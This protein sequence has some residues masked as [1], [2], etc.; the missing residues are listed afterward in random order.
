MITTRYD[1]LK[2]HMSSIDMKI[3]M[4]LRSSYNKSVVA[5]AASITSE[6]GRVHH[7]E[8]QHAA[9]TMALAITNACECYSY[10]LVARSMT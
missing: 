3:R 8:F 1:L 2:R 7:A 10:V 6:P 9:L 4:K 5:A